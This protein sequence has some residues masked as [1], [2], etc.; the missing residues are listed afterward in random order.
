MDQKV[1]WKEGR[2]SNVGRRE[3]MMIPLRL[4]APGGTAD[5]SVY[6]H[7]D[8]YTYTYIYPPA[9]L[10]PSGVEDSSLLPIFPNLT[11]FPPSI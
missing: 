1:K 4:V 10:G 6:T 5:M 3:V 11:S 8:T 7:I 2:R 9:P